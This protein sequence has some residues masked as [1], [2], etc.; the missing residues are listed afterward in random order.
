MGETKESYIEKPVPVEDEEDE[1]TLAAIDEGI[2]DAKAGRTVPA[3]QVR[4]LIR[5]WISGSSTR[6]A[7]IWRPVRRR[8]PDLCCDLNSNPA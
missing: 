6:A 1:A 4:K 2:A 8:C 7:N 3:E 5:K